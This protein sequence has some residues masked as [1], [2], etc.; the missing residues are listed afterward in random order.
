MASPVQQILMVMGALIV[1]VFLLRR[2]KRPMKWAVR[3]AVNSTVG[4]V[5]LVLYDLLGTGLAGA[6]LL[7]VSV[8]NALVVG[9]LGAP[10]F[11]MLAAF[12]WVL[13]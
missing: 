5:C 1:T 7:G 13:G 3:L 6:P 4:L 9:F 11:V 8:Q 2:F 12:P 10:G